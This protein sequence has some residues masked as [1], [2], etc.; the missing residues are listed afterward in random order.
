M[1][2]LTTIGRLL[3]ALPFIFLGLNHFIMM[4][5]YLGTISSYVPLGPFTIMLTGIFLILAG[6]S[7]ILNKYIKV[8]TVLLAILL[9]SFII[10]IHIPNLF[11]ADPAKSTIALVE[12]LKDTSL[13]GGALMIAG[14]FRE[15]DND[16]KNTKA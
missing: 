7:I 16:T 12:L 4:D 14:Y 9:A 13:L 8:S 5:L 2:N 15:K 6:I 3:F 1:K 10:T 11:N